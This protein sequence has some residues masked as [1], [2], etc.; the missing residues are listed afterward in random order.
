MTVSIETKEA[1]LQGRS[2]YMVQIGLANVPYKRSIKTVLGQHIRLGIVNKQ[3]LPQRSN[4][5]QSILGFNDLLY[6]ATDQNTITGFLVEIGETILIAIINIKSP[7]GTH[8]NIPI[9]LFKQGLHKVIFKRILI[10][11]DVPV[12]L[13][14]TTVITIQS[15]TRTEPKTTFVAIISDKKKLRTIRDTI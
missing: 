6:L 4:P 3:S 1:V 11:Q 8:P 15:I 10:I 2:V 9:L 13:I 12:N 7:V 5:D 14:G